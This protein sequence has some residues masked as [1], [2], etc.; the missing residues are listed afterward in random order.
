MSDSLEDPDHMA[1]ARIPE[2]DRRPIN[3]PPTVTVLTNQELT[4]LETAKEI[5]PWWFRAMML[6]AEVI[7][8]R[9]KKYNGDGDHYGNFAS[10]AAIMAQGVE[11]TFKWYI[12]LKFAR[13][14]DHNTDWPDDSFMDGLRDLANYVL[15]WLGYVLRGRTDR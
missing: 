13:V 2:I 11:E 10:A 9:K 14:R 5:Q 4:I 3:L 7:A 6:G 8:D 12:A 1:R 15:L